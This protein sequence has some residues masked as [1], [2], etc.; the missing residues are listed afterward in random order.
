[1]ENS[2]KLLEY[3]LA[4]L[5]ETDISPEKWSIGGG[6][7]LAA[8]YDH[9]LSKDI[10]VFIEDVQFL[11]GLSPRFNN[12][13]E[14]ALDY[15]EMS[16]YI[17]LTFLEG[18]VDFIAGP[19]ITKFSP[20]TEH[21]FGQRLRLDD[22]I[23]IVSKKLYFRGDQVLP[24]DVL[25]LAVV[26]ASDRKYDLINAALAMPEKVNAFTE[27]FT[28]K[29]SNIDFLPYTQEHEDMLLSAGAKIRGKEFSICQEFVECVKTI[30]NIK[31]WIPSSS[32]KQNT[33]ILFYNIAKEVLKS[34]NY[35]WE[36][37]TNKNI[38]SML[39]EKGY[40]YREIKEAMLHSPVREKNM[41]SMIKKL[42][43]GLGR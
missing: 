22:P 14:M 32:Q 28:E 5:N 27:K 42:D 20:R 35:Q 33:A 24:R 19:Q 16:N 25:D 11:S 6:T 13:T 10:D 40:N 36:L 12:L 18:K 3:A 17:S 37:E 2:K 30:E 9:R 8:V 21:F 23:E 39:Y 34:Q 38:I 7:V 15:N 43:K 26:Y 31:E 29:R 4:A 1:M 41:I